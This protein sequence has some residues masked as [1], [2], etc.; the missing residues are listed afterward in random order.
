MEATTEQPTL[1]EIR[2]HLTELS[3]FECELS[4]PV[5]FARYRTSHRYANRFSQGRAL[6]AGDAAHCMSRSA[7]RA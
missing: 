6:I 3:G 7:A 1:D 2:H 5:W 4:D